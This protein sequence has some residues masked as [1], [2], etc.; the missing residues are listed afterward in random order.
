MKAAIA[1]ASEPVV[2]SDLCVEKVS[3]GTPTKLPGKVFGGTVCRSAEEKP[4]KIR[5]DQ[6]LLPIQRL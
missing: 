1:S 5:L 3:Q 4:R 2:E 6:H